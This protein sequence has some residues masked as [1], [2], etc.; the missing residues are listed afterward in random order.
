MDNIGRLIKLAGAREAIEDERFDRVRLN[1]HKH[2]QEVVRSPKVKSRPQH[3]KA[4]AIAASLAVIVGAIFMFSKLSIVPQLQPLA[5]VQRVLGEVRVAGEPAIADSLIP[6]DSPIITGTEGRVAL[7]L[8]GGYL[9]RIDSDSQVRLH[10]RGEISLDK[11]A[12]YIDTTFA[13]VHEPI[14]V[15]TSL[16]TAQDIGTR[17]QVRLA[18][19]VMVVG[20]RDGLVEVSQASQPVVPVVKGSSVELDAKGGVVT[21]SLDTND[22]E[23][24]WIDNVVPPFDIQGATLE[25]YLSWYAHERTLKLVWADAVSEKNAQKAVLAGSIEGSG[26]DEGLDVVQQIAPFEYQVTP[27]QFRVTVK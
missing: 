4:V 14:R 10:S 17:F 5:N 21:T 25:Q 22:P 23:W 15:T 3:L 6:A 11:G 13:S 12:I 24:D 1:V 16:G 2:W 18:G 9:L 8:S 27:D 26:L 7:R 20:V 19:M